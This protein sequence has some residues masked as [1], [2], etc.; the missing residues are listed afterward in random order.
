M[1]CDDVRRVIYFFLDGELGDKKQR[2]LSD[3]LHLCADCEARTTVHRRLRAFIC[4]RLQRANAPDG[5]KTRLSRSLR[6]FRT[7]WQQ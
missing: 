1:G 7:E 2:D 6:A 4:R 5:L 3:H